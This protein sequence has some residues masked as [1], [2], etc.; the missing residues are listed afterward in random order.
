MLQQLSA[1]NN[2]NNVCLEQIPSFIDTHIGAFLKREIPFI[3]RV[4]SL[5]MQARLA[6]TTCGLV[7]PSSLLSFFF[8]SRLVPSQ[9]YWQGFSCV[10]D[11][12]VERH[13]PVRSTRPPLSVDICLVLVAAVSRLR[14]QWLR[15]NQLLWLGGLCFGGSACACGHIVLYKSCAT[16]PQLLVNCLLWRTNVFNISKM[17][18]S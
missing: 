14:F 3:Y 17:L 12:V 13:I 2:K 10:H 1:M 6:N 9:S 16:F 8:F 7:E 11:C 5:C 18:P 15:A 4:F